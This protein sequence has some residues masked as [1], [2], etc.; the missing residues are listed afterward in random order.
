VTP[1]PD[2]RQYAGPSQPSDA[3]AQ[4][5]TSPSANAASVTSVTRVWEN[6]G[7]SN[8]LCT[9]PNRRCAGPG[10]T[11]AHGAPGH[12][13]PHYTPHPQ[14]VPVT[15]GACGG[16]AQ[17]DVRLHSA[18]TRAAGDV[19]R[20]GCCVLRG[21]P[22]RALLSA[23]ARSTPHPVRSSVCAGDRAHTLAAHRRA[24]RVPAE[25]NQT[26]VSAG[27]RTA[28]QRARHRPWVLRSVFRRT[29]RC[30]VCSRVALLPWPH[31]PQS[32]AQA[33]ASHT[34]RC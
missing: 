28:T 5:P 32:R 11:A 29:P 7:P 3:A 31:S 22:H 13:A 20:G 12:A 15:L 25:C 33:V 8:A 14:P 10:H 19:R 34:R 6:Y 21:G 18:G 27:L 4:P 1:D 16:H 17:H 2:P 24:A 23:V 9:I 30:A 26:H